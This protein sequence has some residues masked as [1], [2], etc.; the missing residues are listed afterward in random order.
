MCGI[1]GAWGAVSPG[2][3][4]AMTAALAHRGPDGSGFHTSGGLRLGARRLAIVDVAGGAQPFYNETGEV[5]V[6][7]NAEIYNHRDLRTKLQAMGHRFASQCDT[8]VIVHLYEEYGDRCVDHLRGMFAF[9][10]A[11]GQRLLLARDRLG[12]KPL[13][14]TTVADGVLFASEVKALLRC[15]QV[16][17][18][19]DVQTLIDTCAVGFPVS[20]Q[21]FLAG[22]RSVP[23]GHTMTVHSSPGGMTVETRQYYRLPAEHDASITFDDAQDWLTGLLREAVRSH[24]AA[25]VEVGVILSGGL[26]STVLAMLAHDLGRP[27]QA[28][29]VASE[30]G[31]PDLDQATRVA[32]SLGWQHHAVVMS[33]DDYLEA[34]PGYTRAF[35]EPGR[36]G[37]LGVYYLYQQVGTQLKACLHGEGADELLGGYTQYVDRSQSARVI[38]A[39]LSSLSRLGA[40]PGPRALEV[41]DTVTA[42]QP[43]A[44]YLDRLL[45]ENMRDQLVQNHLELL[46][47]CAMAAGL[48]IRVPFLDDAVAEFV[49]GLPTHY[50]VNLSLGIQKHV[51]KSAALRAWGDNSAV[52]DSVLR[53]KI[54]APTAGSRYQARLSD[55]C[56]RE[57]PDDYLSRHELGPCFAT[58]L[59]LLLHELF[60]EVFLAGRGE[61]PTGFSMREFIAERTGKALPVPA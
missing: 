1:A 2:S 52:A 53:R 56:E 26:D 3:V 17:A 43:R 11:D 19:L 13:Y 37:G 21:T 41:I 40:R 9:A 30:P 51:L 33:F 57:L 50:K 28:F 47:K 7:A 38:A 31:H 22:I 35:E 55:M 6:V 25:D 46:D 58:K 20:E 14:C 49:M 23:P 36:I 12:I 45:T 5:C 54:G 32:S 44:T 60:C 24:L 61:A 59:D 29:S 10:V 15:P 48:E 16:P 34:I 4:E 27:L 42:Q 18:A 8:E 39:R